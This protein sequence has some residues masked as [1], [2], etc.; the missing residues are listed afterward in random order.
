MATTSFI[1]ALTMY[2]GPFWY[3]FAILAGVFGLISFFLYMDK[4]DT[5]RYS[6]GMIPIAKSCYKHKTSTFGRIVDKA[7]T[8]IPFECVTDIEHP[9]LADSEH[10]LCNPNLVS[11][12]QRGRLTNGVPTLNYVLPYHFPMGFSSTL[13]LTQLMK[14]IRNEH[15]ELDWVSDDLRII[16]LMFCSDK[17]LVSNCRTAIETY[18]KM[19]VDIPEL[20]LPVEDDYQEES[21]EELEEELLEDDSNE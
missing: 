16:S 21:E 4:S 20:F 9:G 2:F 10:T 8:E 19:G 5:K 18:V 14:H 13:A 15:K 7:G 11:V 17:Y 6:A 3:V 1:N 12:K